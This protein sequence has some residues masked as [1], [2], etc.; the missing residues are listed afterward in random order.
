MH[1]M[2]GRVK[3]LTP[4]LL[5]GDAP[6][7][8]ASTLFL[9]SHLSDVVGS[10]VQRRAPTKR[11]KETQTPPYPHTHLSALRF[12][13]AGTR[14]EAPFCQNFRPKL[15]STLL[16]IVSLNNT[17]IVAYNLLLNEWVFYKGLESNIDEDLIQEHLQTSALKRGVRSRR[18]WL[19]PK[20]S[21]LR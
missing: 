5:E 17:H 10:D 7:N 4:L 21:S 14:R 15:G 8:T 12:A 19:C 2:Q 20:P 1:G 16:L 3:G 6:N 9:N 11:E 18:P 13:R